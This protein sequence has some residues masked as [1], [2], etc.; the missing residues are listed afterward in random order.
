MHQEDQQ[1]SSNTPQL[2][3]NNGDFTHEETAAGWTSPMMD[4]FI[5]HTVSAP[6]Y[7]GQE[8]Q[9]LLDFPEDFGNYCARNKHFPNDERSSIFRFWIEHNTD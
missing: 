7:G 6:R 3:L 9:F 8:N 5:P 4:R 1:P 2:E